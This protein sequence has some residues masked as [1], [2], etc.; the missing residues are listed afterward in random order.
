MSSVLAGLLFLVGKILSKCLGLSLDPL[1][2]IVLSL[3]MGLGDGWPGILRLIR[4][5]LFAEP[6]RR[7]AHFSDIQTA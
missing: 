2:M 6:Q 4:K 1:H 5:N 3:C 7:A